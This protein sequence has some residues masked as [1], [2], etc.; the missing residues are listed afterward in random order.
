MTWNINRFGGVWDW[1]RGKKDKNKEEREGKAKESIR[2]IGQLIS[3][4]DDVVVLQEFPYYE[5]P[6]YGKN[7]SCIEYKHWKNLFKEKGLT[8]IEPYGKELN[9]TV[10]VVPN[11]EGVWVKTV[12]DRKSRLGGRENSAA[13]LFL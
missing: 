12:D 11:K 6:Y 13:W 1:Y 3:D 7:N 9:V 2:Y 4:K 5:L 10:A 8:V